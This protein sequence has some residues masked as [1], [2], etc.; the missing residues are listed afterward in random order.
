MT[1]LNS[2]NFRQF[3][4]RYAAS[5]IALVIS[6]VL[7]SV[8]VAGCNQSK[9]GSVLDTRTEPTDSF[10]FLRWFTHEED[11]AVTP[12]DR[13]SCDFHQTEDISASLD[14]PGQNGHMDVTKIHNYFSCKD[15]DGVGTS[16]QLKSVELRNGK[17]AII[18]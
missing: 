6:A 1:P 9:R 16:I 5:G 7:L 18:T 13:L 11:R 3:G 8:F 17:A 10:S 14:G 15:R 4:R 12:E 2:R